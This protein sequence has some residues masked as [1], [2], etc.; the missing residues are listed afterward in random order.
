M[1]SEAWWSIWWPWMLVWLL[2]AAGL[3][4][5]LVLTLTLLLGGRRSGGQ[6]IIPGICFYLHDRSV[7]DH[8]QMRGYTAALR[9]EVEQRTSDSKD[10]SVHAK[11]FGLT[12][13]GGKRD[14]SEIVSKY[15]EVAEPISVIG[16][17][18]DV[19]EEKGVIVHV[20]L[21]NRAVGRNGALDSALAALPGGGSGADSG[22]VASRRT[23]RLRDIE[24]FVL[25]RGRFRKI[26]E[27]PETTVFLAPY[28]D[29]E[30][31]AEGPH[32]RV[33]CATEGLR[34]EVGRGTF[35][36]RCLGKVQDWNAEDAVLEVQAMAIFR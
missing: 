11:V 3:V 30:N 7:M 13:G 31:P 19:L 24:D 15:L 1:T 32:V 16:I 9:K 17:I 21:V 10:G 29:P 25:I 28:G 4:A 36:A 26:S 2:T 23:V 18:M 14:N 6:K 34:T 8:Y 35:S 33:T 5:L 12:A 20:D 27:S 22:P